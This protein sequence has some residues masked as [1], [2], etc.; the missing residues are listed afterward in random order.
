MTISI[1]AKMNNGLILIS[2][3]RNGMIEPS[4]SQEQL[5][6]LTKYCGVVSSSEERLSTQLINQFRKELE[7]HKI[8][9]LSEEMIDLAQNIFFQGY[10]HWLG[11]RDPDFFPCYYVI[12]G[13]SDKE[14][15]GA[16][17]FS[18]PDFTPVFQLTG[19]SGICAIG[20]DEEFR[21]L[22]INN[23]ILLL[24][25]L[26]KNCNM[27]IRDMSNQQVA[28]MIAFAIDTIVKS[29]MNLAE[30]G[31]VQVAVVEENGFY[32]FPYTIENRTG[33]H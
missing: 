10:N 4:S 21:Q 30:G 2:D 1:V 16:Y 17:F 29:Q 23:T 25:Q 33:K 8:E 3:S 13:K 27:E 26:S 31:N 28:M 6:S 9:F 12:A 22:V 24:G 15:L 7:K 32:L 5:F 18:S 20:G 11:D 19:P 14:E